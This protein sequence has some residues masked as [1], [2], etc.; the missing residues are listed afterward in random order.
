M[1]KILLILPLLFWLGCEDEKEDADEDCAGVEGG[2]A[3]VDSCDVCVGGNTG[4]VACTQDCSGE[5]GG[6]AFVNA[7]D[8]CVGGNT[9]IEEG[10]C[11]PVTDIDGNTYQTVA[12][13]D[14]VWMQ[15]NLK[16][17]KYVN[18][19]EIPTGYNNSEWSD[20]NSTQTGAYTVYDDNESN[21]DTYGYLYNFYAV[22]DER[23]ICPDGWHIPTDDEI[24]EL[25]MYLGMSQEEA[26]YNSWRGTNEGSKLAGRAD[27]WNDNDLD[28]NPEFGTS[29]F[30]FLPGGCRWA[31]SGLYSNMGESGF[32]WSSTEFGDGAWYRYLMDINSEISR[33]HG[34]ERLGFSV[35]CVK[36]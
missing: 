10:Y 22:D 8:Y 11:D 30:N 26:D 6:Y 18:G 23:G 25:E 36:D 17:T 28:N 13:G 19:N 33:T 12:I 20:L 14:Q 4:E 35:R 21:A 31:S 9:G 3:Q 32:F 34:S 27:L 1:K 7:C 5:W 15:E 2:T 16:V 29:G 24:K